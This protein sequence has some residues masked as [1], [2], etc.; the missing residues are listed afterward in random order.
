MTDVP[1]PI[2]ESPPSIHAIEDSELK[3]GQRDLDMN[4][5]ENAAKKLR[6]KLDLVILP[7]FLVTQA[8]QFMDKT[9]LNY[10]N[11]FGYQEA[12]GLKGNQFN[13]LSAM[14]YAGYFFGQYP[15]G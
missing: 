2:P 15:C 7:M 14:V 10:A 9:S 12:L 3:G 6:W 5:R 13:Y 4:D 11:L 8:L 1:K